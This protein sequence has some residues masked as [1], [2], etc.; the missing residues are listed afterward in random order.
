MKILITTILLF[1]AQ[2]AFA[3]SVCFTPSPLCGCLIVESIQAAHKSILVQA[4]VFTSKPIQKALLDA[5]K[6]GVAVKLILDKTE[7][8]NPFIA[9]SHI[10]TWIDD[11]PRIAHNKIMLIDDKLIITGSYNFSKSASKNA[12]NVLFIANDDALY[13]G[14]L[15]NWFYRQSV[16]KKVG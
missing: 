11:T 9:S 16:S 6:R 3:I 14:Y 1:L 7:S 4:Y 5:K 2:T 15:R 10:D 8:N 13:E 12:E